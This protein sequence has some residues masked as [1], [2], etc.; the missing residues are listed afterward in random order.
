MGTTYELHHTLVPIA[1]PTPAGPGQPSPAVNTI[2][3]FQSSK[4]I[5]GENGEQIQAIRRHQWSQITHLMALEHWHTR[6]WHILVGCGNGNQF[7]SEAGSHFPL[8]TSP[9]EYQT[10]NSMTDKYAP[11]VRLSLIWKTN[12]GDIVRHIMFTGSN[13]NDLR[14]H[15]LRYGLIINVDGATGRI[16]HSTQLEAGSVGCVSYAPDEFQKAIQNISSGDVDLYNQPSTPTVSLTIKAGQGKKIQ[17]LAFGEDG[18]ILVCGSG[19]G[20][21]FVF[22]SPKGQRIQALQHRDQSTICALATGCS[23]AVDAHQARSELGSDFAKM[24]ESILKEQEQNNCLMLYIKRAAIVLT[25]GTS[26]AVLMLLYIALKL[27]II[28]ELYQRSRER[29]GRVDL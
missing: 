3:F 17:G 22:T 14:Y 16:L 21:I 8:S 23:V 18:A 24:Q 13:V 25:L 5:S 20:R 11:I 26:A 1:A 4:L 7:M 28:E 6:S 12:L 29:L 10:V 15:T 19:S 27:G 9:V 2:I